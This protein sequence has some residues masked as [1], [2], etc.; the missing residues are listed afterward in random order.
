MIL[1]DLEPNE[2]APVLFFI[3]GGGYQEG[4]GDMYGPDFIVEKRVILVTINY[5]V[6]MFGFLS[7]NTTEYSGNMGLK[8]QLLALK[9]IYENIEN[10]NGDNNQITIIGQSSGKCD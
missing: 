6:G 10:F 1:A 4:N 3:H 2:K 5:R 7:F 8:D 9:W